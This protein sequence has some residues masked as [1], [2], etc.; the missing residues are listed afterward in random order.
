MTIAKDEAKKILFEEARK[1]T[2]DSIDQEWSSRIKSFS[3]I[4]ER[5]T[6]THIAF[7]GTAILAKC[8]SLDVDVFS[9]KAKGDFPGAYSARGLGH[10]V[11][12]PHSP[13][14]GINLGVTGREPLNNQPYFQIDRVSKDITVHANAIPALLALCDILDIL[15]GITSKDEML[16]VLRAYIFVRRKYCASYGD[17]ENM[18][19]QVSVDELIDKVNFFVSDNSEG[20]KR[21]QAV[22]AGLM[23]IFAGHDCVETGRVNDPDRHLPGDVGIRMTP[24]SQEWSKILE[25]RDKPVTTEDL[26]LFAQKSAE[27]GV[28]EAIVVA[29]ANNQSSLDEDKAR[30][31]AKDRG[32]ALTIFFG[33]E[34]FISQ[35]LLWSD[36]P[37]LQG[38]KIA[39]ELIYGRIVELEVSEKGAELWANIFK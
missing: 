39:A 19:Q 8:V 9:V 28:R 22:V 3:E 11:L 32:V 13:E 10:N 20:G 25:V 37:Q 23:D 36:S 1:A 27:A 26:I 15:Q 4:C 21:A 30:K 16:S 29:V 7:L 17:F 33:W 14:L 12:V 38:L 6:K 31:W 2:E 34:G 5:S 18:G 35:L 24:E